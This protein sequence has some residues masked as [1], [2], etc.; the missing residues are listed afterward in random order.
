[1]KRKAT[2]ASPRQVLFASDQQMGRWLKSHSPKQDRQR[3]SDEFL[4]QHATEYAAVIS[5]DRDNGGRDDKCANVFHERLHLM[6]EQYS[7]L[8]LIDILCQIVD[9]MDPGGKEDHDEIVL[10]AIAEVLN[11]RYLLRHPDDE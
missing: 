11:S 5:A 7:K 10:Q 3:Y 1:M 2:I 9:D 8:E 6:L 4:Q